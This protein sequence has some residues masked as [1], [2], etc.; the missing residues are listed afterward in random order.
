MDKTK[1]YERKARL[2]PVIITMAF[3]LGLLSFFLTDLLPTQVNLI[4][5]ISIS[6]IPAGLLTA[7]F[8]FY[9]KNF[10]RSISK[11]IF[12]FR[13]FKEDESYMPTTELLLWNNH[14]LSDSYKKRIRDKIKSMFDTTLYSREKETKN[15][16]EARRLIAEVIP[17]LRNKTRDDDILFGYN[18]Y[19]G[20]IRNVLG[21]C[22]VAMIILIAL[23]FANLKWMIVPTIIII[24]PFALYLLCILLAKPLLKHYGYE[25]ARKLYDAFMQTNS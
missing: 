21:G 5:R 15:E 20:S 25:Y 1:I 23:F 12:Q 8:S 24:I 22:V 14:R 10:I 2:Y 18:C 13:Y 4:T 6:L 16:K 17:Q 9:L 3:P 7:A 19:F 11:W